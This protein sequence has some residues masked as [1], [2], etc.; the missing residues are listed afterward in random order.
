MHVSLKESLKM[1]YA[2]LDDAFLK[3]VNAYI[4][5]RRFRVPS[6]IFCEIDVT[7]NEQEKFRMEHPSFSKKGPDKNM[8]GQIY[9]DSDV[10]LNAGRGSLLDDEIKRMH[11]DIIL[12]EK[13]LNSIAEFRRFLL[14]YPVMVFYSRDGEKGHQM[15]SQDMFSIHSSVV[16]LLENRFCFFHGMVVYIEDDAFEEALKK[17]FADKREKPLSEEDFLKR[18]KN[19]YCMH[20][21]FGLFKFRDLLAIFPKEES[22]EDDG[23][24]SQYLQTA[25]GV[26]ATFANRSILLSLRL[27]RQ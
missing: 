12:K 6:E 20:V 27:L 2:R 25:Y 11:A 10:Y 5:Q 18:D 21:L 9:W 26:N 14:E 15:L 23:D 24:V 3:F 22:Y 13:L 7:Q 19:A 17:R 8:V 4:N 16:H 1:V